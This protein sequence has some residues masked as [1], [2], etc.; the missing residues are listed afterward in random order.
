MLKRGN[1]VEIF[2]GVGFI[3]GGWRDLKSVLYQVGGSRSGWRW[4][5]H[6]GMRQAGRV[7]SSCCSCR[8]WLSPRQGQHML[9]RRSA[10]DSSSLASSPKT[11]QIFTQASGIDSSV[12]GGQRPSPTD[13]RACGVVDLFLAYMRG[14]LDSS[15]SLP[16]CLLTHSRITSFHRIFSLFCSVCLVCV[17]GKAYLPSTP[18][19][20]G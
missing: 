6:L 5:L 7:D 3:L 2:G 15:G 12:N 10:V 20:A 9:P 16:I 14:W 11:N 17:L 18:A 19:S 4:H 13:E 8:R 1:G